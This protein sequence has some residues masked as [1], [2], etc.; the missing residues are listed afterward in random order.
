M[1]LERFSRA[2]RLRWLWF[3]WPDV[4]RPWVG[5]EVPCDETDKQLFRAST[6]I[7]IG[8]GEKAQSSWLE[9]KAPRD[10]APNLYKLAWRKH[11]SVAE[12]LHNYNWTRGLWWMATADE[13]A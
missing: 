13:I 6:V 5:F 4:D 3:Q 2:L 12:D 11:N 1:D 9:G 8:N 7:T 10:L